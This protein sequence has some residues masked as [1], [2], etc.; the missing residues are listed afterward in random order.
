MRT[1]LASLGIPLADIALMNHS[2]DASG[3]GAAKALTTV[4]AAQGPTDLV[5][6][7]LALEHRLW[8]RTRLLQ[9]KDDEYNY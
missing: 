8:V 1:Y 7:P 5:V 6:S 2:V 4:A 9:E 3:L